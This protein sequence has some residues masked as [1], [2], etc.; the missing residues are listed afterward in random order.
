[1]TRI[2]VEQRAGLLT[3]R[4]KVKV[5]VKVKMGVMRSVAQ[6]VMKLQ[7]T[8]SLDELQDALFFILSFETL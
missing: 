6:M 5:K 2:Q 4:W 3:G 7:S 1:V 8:R